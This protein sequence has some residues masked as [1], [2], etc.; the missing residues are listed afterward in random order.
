LAA[1]VVT[2]DVV[3]VDAPNPACAS[4]VPSTAPAPLVVLR[5]ENS[6]MQ[7]D[8]SA[9]VAEM[10]AVIVR[11]EV[12]VFGADQMDVWTPETV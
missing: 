5:P 8:A 12:E 3:I 10:V 1:V 9:P 6:S 2:A 11:A 4:P 7:I